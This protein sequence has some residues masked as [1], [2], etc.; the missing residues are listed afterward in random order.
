MTNRTDIQ[1]LLDLL[2]TKKNRTGKRESDIEKGKRT[3]SF[4]AI[5]KLDQILDYY[6]FLFIMAV[7]KFRTKLSPEQIESLLR[8]FLHIFLENH[9]QSDK[10]EQEISF[11]SLSD[12]FNEFIF[13][14]L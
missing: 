13:Q 8:R 4:S 14:F 9:L 5:Q 3:L 11:K 10:L 12:E 2:L 6:P 1:K 7:G